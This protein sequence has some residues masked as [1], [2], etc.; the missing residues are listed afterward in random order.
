MQEIA[1]QRQTCIG[2]FFGM[3]LG[4]KNIV[5]C[6]GHRVAPAVIGFTYAVLRMS[7]GGV[8]T[9]QEIDLA[10]VG[11][12][13]PYGMRLGDEHLVPAHLRHLEAAAVS[14]RLAFELKA[15]DF[16]GD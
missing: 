9:V 3:E 11:N 16:A 12:A 2:T 4:G 13:V 8:V 1:V 7:W 6:D 14:L 10:L 15:P 5:A